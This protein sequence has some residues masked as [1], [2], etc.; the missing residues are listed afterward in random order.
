MGK[1]RIMAV[2][3][4]QCSFSKLQYLVRTW[5]GIDVLAWDGEPYE[6]FIFFRSIPR[7]ENHRTEDVGEQDATYGAGEQVCVYEPPLAGEAV[8][9]PVLF[10]GC[11][12][13]NQVHDN[14]LEVE[15]ETK[16]VMQM[17]VCVFHIQSHWGQLHLRE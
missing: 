2:T 8:V 3:S 15:S 5:F 12:V 4:I 1:V 9:P 14:V 17:S 11:S 6:E 7:R 10:D 13:E 16:Q